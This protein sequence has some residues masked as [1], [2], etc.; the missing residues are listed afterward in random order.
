MTNDKHLAH[1]ERGLFPAIDKNDTQENS[2]VNNLDSI[3]CH[4]QDTMQK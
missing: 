4:H 3:S 1:Q 2:Q